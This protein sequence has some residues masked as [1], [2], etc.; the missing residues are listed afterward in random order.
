MCARRELSVCGG[1]PQRFGDMSTRPKKDGVSDSMLISKV[2]F[3]WRG[4][5]M[6]DGGWRVGEEGGVGVVSFWKGAMN[7]GG[8]V[9]PWSDWGYGLA[10]GNG[11]FIIWSWAISFMTVS[12][13]AAMGL[14]VVAV[15][16]GVLA[17]FPG[18]SISSTGVVH[19]S[20]A[21]A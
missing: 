4:V 18:F 14:R 7:M 12:R 20:V 5:S 8:G 13:L 16:F 9:G 3:N 21:L 11:P 17:C 6:D 2:T 19:Y 15:A 1:S 10:S